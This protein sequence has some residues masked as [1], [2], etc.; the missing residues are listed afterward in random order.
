M[1]NKIFTTQGENVLKNLTIDEAEIKFILKE[2]ET[3]ERDIKYR[4]MEIKKEMN[5]IDEQIQV[6]TFSGK[7]TKEKLNLNY[8]DLYQSLKTYQEHFYNSSKEAIEELIAEQWK[9]NN[10]WDSFQRLPYLQRRILTIL[11]V[12]KEK[13]NYAIKILKISK[14]KFEENRKK[15]LEK[16]LESYKQSI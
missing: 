13:Y 11:Y 8:N 6:V 14:K 2:K 4:I 12:E 15:A 3:I 7:N 1:D 9:I 5:N 16:I 10:V